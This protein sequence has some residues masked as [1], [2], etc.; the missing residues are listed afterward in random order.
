MYHVSFYVGSQLLCLALS[1]GGFAWFPDLTNMD[2]YFILPVV[3][4]TT[5]LAINEVRLSVVIRTSQCIN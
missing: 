2:H 3:M 1:T 4:M 5:N